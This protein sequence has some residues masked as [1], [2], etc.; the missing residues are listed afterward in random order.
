MNDYKT[1][2]NTNPNKTCFETRRIIAAGAV[3]LLLITSFLTSIVVGMEKMNTGLQAWC[4]IMMIFSLGGIVFT[5]LFGVLR[6]QD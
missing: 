5:I 6:V 1:E 3:V 2:V 4:L